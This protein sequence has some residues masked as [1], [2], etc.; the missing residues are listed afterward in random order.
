MCKDVKS[1]KKK[2]SNI[3]YSSIGLD[4]MKLSLPNYPDNCLALDISRNVR[5]KVGDVLEC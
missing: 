1:I 5:G 3:Q 2:Y 4:Q